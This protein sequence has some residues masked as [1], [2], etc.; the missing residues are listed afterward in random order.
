[1]KVDDLFFVFMETCAART[2]L[3][4]CKVI[5]TKFNEDDLMIV[6]E[7]EGMPWAFPS[8]DCRHSGNQGITGRPAKIGRAHV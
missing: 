2:Y 5:K 3:L 4:V 8:L 6:D 1:M 7:E